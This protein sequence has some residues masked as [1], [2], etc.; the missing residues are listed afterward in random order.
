MK[1]LE[2]WMA[3]HPFVLLAGL[4][5]VL[6][7][8]SIWGDIRWEKGHRREAFFL[9]SL[10]MSADADGWITLQFYNW[11]GLA[12]IVIVISYLALIV[13]AFRLYWRAVEESRI[14][15]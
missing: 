6:M 10:V 13:L 5:L 9:G 14:R 15:I 12:L 8:Q 3:E 11:A 1:K 2:D 4:P 7:A